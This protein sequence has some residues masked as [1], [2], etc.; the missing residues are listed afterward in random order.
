MVIPSVKDEELDD[1]FPKGVRVH[2]VP[3]TKKYLR[4]TPQPE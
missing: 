2:E 1:L 3:S 4:V